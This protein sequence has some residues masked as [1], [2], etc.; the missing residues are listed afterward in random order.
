MRAHLSRTRSYLLL[1][2]L[3][4]PIAPLF[5]ARIVPTTPARADSTR[6]PEFTRRLYLRTPYLRGADVRQVQQRLVAL[7]YK[8][9]GVVDG[10]FGPKTDAA[11]RMLQSRNSLTVDGVVGPQTWAALFGSAA[12]GPAELAPIAIGAYIMGGVQNGQWLDSATTGVKLSGGE[13]YTTYDT[14]GVR[15]TAVG[16]K[17][18]T[19]FRLPCTR[20]AF[21]SFT[22]QPTIAYTVAVGGG[23]D[24]LPR[25]ASEIPTTNAVYRK[26]IADLLR[27]RGIQNPD[28]RL[29]RVLRV[30]IEGD[31]T[32]EVLIGAHRFD[33]ATAAAGDYSL[34]VLQKVVKGKV[35][36]IPIAENIYPVTQKP[37]PA[38]QEPISPY[39]YTLLGTFDLNGD[40]RLEV[41]VPY[42]YYEGNGVEVFAING[43]NVQS[44]LWGGCGV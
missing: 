41:I 40:G 13:L 3:L 30:D 15:G 33:Y 44:V 23:W 42:I 1:F 34:V 28:V 27:A 35:V 21:V 8:Q 2:L 25:L 38:P 29:T 24:A 20:T 12:R 9:V 19:E 10:V 39:E 16:G 31:G 36:T 37:Y 32:D 6:V 4:L 14:K 18:N 26:A 5:D 17:P 43:T 11:V 7:G 22:P